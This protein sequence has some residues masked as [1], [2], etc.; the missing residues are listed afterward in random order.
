MGLQRRSYT[1]VALV[2]AATAI[3]LAA[4]GPS[5]Q[6]LFDEALAEGWAALASDD[7]ELAEERLSAAGKLRPDDNDYVAASQAF[8]VTVASRNAFME[9]ERLADSGRLLAARDAFL[10]VSQEDLARFEQAQ[11]AARSMESLWLDVTAATLDDLL[12]AKD[13]SGVVQA[14]ETARSDFSTPALDN[15][16]IGPRADQ[17]H[18]V[19]AEVGLDLVAEEQFNSTDSLIERVTSIFPLSDSEASTAVREVRELSASE[20]ARIT[21]IRSEEAARRQQEALQEMQPSRPAPRSPSGDCPSPVTDPDGFRQCLDAR[22]AEVLPTPDP[23]DAEAPS[24]PSESPSADSEGPSFRDSCPTFDPGIEASI[25]TITGTISEPDAFGNR[26]LNLEFSGSITNAS[27]GWMRIFQSTYVLYYGDERENHPGHATKHTT[28]E[29]SS[30]EGWLSPGSIQRLVRGD[31]P[32]HG[33]KDRI[34]THIEFMAGA[35]LRAEEQPNFCN[36]NGEQSFHYIRVPI[37]Y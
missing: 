24:S 4:C 17:V 21:R 20:R 6:A 26:R 36:P 33:A 31:A 27:N 34:P 23:S 25:G 22:L 12:S 29:G 18:R 28:V 7:L 16:V 8:N 32:P 30:D 9:A 3:L 13:L 15:Q 5:E 1:R 35:S 11:A 37:S 14:V 2:G 19:L 10:Q